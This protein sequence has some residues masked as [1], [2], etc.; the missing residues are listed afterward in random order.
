MTLDSNDTRDSADR[1]ISV[2]P[3]TQFTECSQTVQSIIINYRHEIFGLAT[4]ISAGWPSYLGPI[5][6]EDTPIIGFDINTQQAEWYKKN[7]QQDKNCQIYLGDISSP[8]NEMKEKLLSG[9][10]MFTSNIP[11][12]LGGITGRADK[13]STQIHNQRLSNFISFS[14]E[15][16]QSG[17]FNHSSAHILISSLRASYLRKLLTKI[18]QQTTDLNNYDILISYPTQTTFIN[19]KHYPINN[20]GIISCYPVHP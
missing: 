2:E 18:S 14:K 5:L 19:K 3:Y 10:F 16:L 13:T 9:N 1:F 12:W 20:F 8:S 4:P 7:Y 11:D 17:C 6:I 15:F